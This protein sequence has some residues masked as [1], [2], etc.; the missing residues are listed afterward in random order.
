MGYTAY[1]MRT[2]HYLQNIGTQL[3]K[4]EEGWKIY[5]DEGVSGRSLFEDRPAGSKLINDVKKGKVERVIVLRLDRL[6]RNTSDILKTINTI[7]M[8]YKVPIT[9]LNEGITTLN[10]KGEITPTTGL[11]VNVLSSLS[12]FFYH[13]T[14]EKIL[15]GVERGK[16]LGKYTGRKN[17]SVEPPEKYLSKPTNKKIVEMLE[18][19]VGIRR[20]SRVLE[21]SPNTIYKVKKT[22]E[23]VLN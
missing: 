10:D 22:R 7:S 19:G 18:S 23:M 6:G 3:D 12:E 16:N 20:I 17:G 15:V 4:I 13:Q 2:S 11:L 14:R 8:E 9:S 21:V 5:K 1:Y